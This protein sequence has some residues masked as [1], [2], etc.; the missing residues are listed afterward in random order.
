MHLCTCPLPGLFFYLFL[1]NVVWTIANSFLIKYSSDLQV[2][3]TAIESW[4]NLILSSGRTKTVKF[5][6]K[7]K[8]VTEKSR[9][10]HNHKPQPF[11]NTKR[12]RKPTN[13]NKHKSNKRTKSAKI[14]FL[15]SK[16]GN[17]IAKRT[18]KRKK[19]KITQG[20]T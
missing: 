20:K 10:C 15:F 5:K 19:K 11:P 7:K 8:K 16:Q 13:Q 17:C 18:K 1:K 4:M 3:R 12:K 14:S 2:M 6:K 9:E